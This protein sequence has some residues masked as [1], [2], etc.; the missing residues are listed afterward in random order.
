M[1]SWARHWQL[2]PNGGNLGSAQVGW[3]RTF[4][5]P[6]EVRWQAELQG[7]ATEG[8]IYG[9]NCLRATVFSVRRELESFECLGFSAKERTGVFDDN[10]R[11]LFL[12]VPARKGEW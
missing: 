3:T 6:E 8:T 12:R 11:P 5:W 2:R 9:N 10:L 7:T 1:R 4:L